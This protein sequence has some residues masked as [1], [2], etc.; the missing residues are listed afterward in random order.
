MCLKDM[1]MFRFPAQPT[2]E[3]AV[4][5]ALNNS[6]KCLTLLGGLFR[7]QTKRLSFNLNGGVCL[8]I[9]AVQRAFT[10]VA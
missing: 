1:F 6:R 3:L 9:L 8:C 2:A 4:A 7:S 10:T 5:R